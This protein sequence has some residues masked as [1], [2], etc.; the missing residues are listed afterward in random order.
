MSAT[1][2][3]SGHSEL[4][5][6]TA[7]PTARRAFP[8]RLRGLLV[9]LPCWAAVALGAYLTPAASGHGTHEQ[10]NVP[11][12]SFLA[13]RGWPCPGCGLTTSFSAMARGRVGL[14]WRSQ[15]FGVASFLA[16]IALGIVGSTELIANRAVLDRLRPSLWWALVLVA[17][18]LAGWGWKAAAGYLR[19][20]YPLP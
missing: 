2:S 14:A 11:G 16:V 20:D 9:A 19:G 12:C 3:S 18:L 4:V 7:E 1:V 5:P 6:L 10:L 8:L 15:P 13:R 17:G